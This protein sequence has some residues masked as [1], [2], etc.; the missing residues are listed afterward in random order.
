MYQIVGNASTR[1]GR[2]LWM[3][4]ELGL[5]YEHIPAKPSSEAA[6]AHNPA[7]KVPILI[8]GGTPITDSTAILQYLADKHG[9]LTFAAGTLDRARQDSFTFLILDEFDACLWTAARH[10]FVLPKEMR[11]PAIKPP[12][13]WEFD[14]SQQALA[15]RI[16]P[17]PFVMGDAMTVPDIVLTEC[18]GWAI[19]AK[20]P[21]IEPSLADYLARMQARPA[22][23]RAMAL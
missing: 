8:D 19:E 15:S 4:E 21:P 2:V 7:G 5:P 11:D 13:K 1:A 17:G 12:L 18:L 10:S 6:F 3:L 22:F 16:G 9:A 14:R 23:K 20:F